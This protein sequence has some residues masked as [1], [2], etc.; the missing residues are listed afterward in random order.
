MGP[1]RTCY[2]YSINF[3]NI[4]CVFIILS[5]FWHKRCGLSF[6]FFDDDALMSNFSRQFNFQD[7]VLFCIFSCIRKHFVFELQLLF[8]EFLLEICRH[9]SSDGV[10][11][12]LS[13]CVSCLSDLIHFLSKFHIN[14]VAIP[15]LLLHP[16]IIFLKELDLL[17]ELPLF[18]Q[19]IFGLGGE[20]LCVADGSLIL[21]LHNR[22][23]VFQGLYLLFIF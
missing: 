11:F 22:Y 14:I 1:F 10:F 21:I 9:F 3:R 7:G 17:G 23:V 5:N 15:R 19:K 16:F 2:N 4:I 20:H 6:Q 8:G 18:F 13:K 12:L